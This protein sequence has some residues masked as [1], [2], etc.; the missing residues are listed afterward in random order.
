M[1]GGWA[2]L[3]LCV[4]RAGPAPGDAVS[5]HVRSERGADPGAAL[6]PEPRGAGAG[7]HP[8][9]APRRQRRPDGQLRDEDGRTSSPGRI[10]SI[11]SRYFVEGP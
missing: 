2:A 3:T 4:V 7:P 11:S 10:L 6:A 9:A 1:F 5:Q 8:P